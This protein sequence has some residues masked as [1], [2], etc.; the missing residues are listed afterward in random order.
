MVG[1]TEPNR[2]EPRAGWRQTLAQWVQSPPGTAASWQHQI[3]VYWHWRTLEGLSLGEAWEELGMEPATARAA[4]DPASP[5]SG[6]IPSELFSRVL[7][8]SRASGIDPDDSGPAVDITPSPPTELPDTPEVGFTLARPNPPRPALY[9]PR[10]G[11]KGKLLNPPINSAGWLAEL[12]IYWRRRTKEHESL[13]QAWTDLRMHPTNAETAL[14]QNLA[15]RGSIPPELIGRVVA[16]SEAED[17]DPNDNVEGII[18]Y[19]S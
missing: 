3:S 5:D 17:I 8:R 12:H 2:Y 7:A 4:L 11:W 1:F 18:L 16:R 14:N 15:D 13:M 19:P 6:R 9:Q 10:A